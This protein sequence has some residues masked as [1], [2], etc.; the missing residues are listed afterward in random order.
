[1]SA[2]ASCPVLTNCPPTARQQPDQSATVL[3]TPT[4][5]MSRVSRPHLPVPV[6]LAPRRC[7]PA[8]TLEREQFGGGGW[9]G[10]A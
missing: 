4:G 1:M 7:T 5:R 2:A 10:G 3:Q 8:F 9:Q 6:F